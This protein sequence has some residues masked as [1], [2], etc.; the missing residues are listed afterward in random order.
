LIFL[1]NTSNWDTAFRLELFCE[2]DLTRVILMNNYSFVTYSK[3]IVSFTILISKSS[4]L[5]VR[6]SFAKPKQITLTVRNVSFPNKDPGVTDLNFHKIRRERTIKMS[7]EESAIILIDLWD[8]ENKRLPCNQ[9]FEKIIVQKIAPLLKAARETNM[10]VIHA[11]HRQ[12][13]WDGICRQKSLDLRGPTDTPRSELPKWVKNKEISPLQWPT[14]EFVFRVGEYSRYSRFS[15]PNYI[16]Y[17]QIRGIHKAVLPMKRDREYIASNR[18]R[19][20]SILRKHRV[21]HLFYA[22]FATN[23]CVL[24]RPI[25]IR[26]MSMIRYNVM[27]LRDA[28]IGSEFGNTWKNLDIT[29]GAIADIEINYGFSTTVDALLKELCRIRKIYFD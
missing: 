12:I 19:V 8:A 22:G 1:P 5:S 29:K 3:S 14:V 11:P 25:G 9:L 18:K 28:T 15:N 13:G 24:N 23:Q 20:Q 7:V 27:I 10:V 16:P 2:S 21:L 6:E 4:M 17:T 26:N